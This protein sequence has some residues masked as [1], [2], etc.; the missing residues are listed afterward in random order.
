MANADHLYQNEYA[1]FHLQIDISLSFLSH[2]VPTNVYEIA[3][4]QP[5]HILPSPNG[6]PAT[7]NPAICSFY[8]NY[9]SSIPAHNHRIQNL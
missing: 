9:Y 2:V 5:D 1:I 7:H 6:N 4:Y 8:A 3:F